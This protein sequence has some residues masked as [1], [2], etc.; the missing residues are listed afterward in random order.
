MNIV[1]QEQR[2]NVTREEVLDEAKLMF[3]KALSMLKDKFSEE[4]VYETLFNDHK[5]FTIAYPCVVTHMV[6]KQYSPVVFNEF[7]DHM[8]ENTPNS[9]DK[10][11]ML[12]AT[13]TRMSYKFAHKKL[14]KSALDKIYNDT[15]KDLRAE[16]K[17]VVD[18]FKNQ[19]PS[20]P[21]R[22]S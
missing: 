9:E 8:M 19:M 20:R 15:L 22:S 7:I 16:S 2:K 5:D 18:E 4:E 14:S 3:A 12:Q 6:N 17:K 21:H 10:F 1:K 13:Y 11:L